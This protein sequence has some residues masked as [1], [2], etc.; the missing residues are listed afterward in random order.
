ME[1][2]LNYN[3]L[4]YDYDKQVIAENLKENISIV[5]ETLEKD[6]LRENSTES[7][8]NNGVGLKPTREIIRGSVIYEQNGDNN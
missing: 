2:Q 4:D 5:K 7:L 6:I 1:N 3:L 8:F